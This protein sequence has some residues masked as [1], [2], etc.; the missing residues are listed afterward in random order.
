MS[1]TIHIYFTDN[2]LYWIEVAFQEGEPMSSVKS[3][4]LPYGPAIEEKPYQGHFL[5]DILIDG[6]YWYY[7]SNYTS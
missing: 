7:T 5:T 1:F 4:L 2:K 6:Q 3:Y